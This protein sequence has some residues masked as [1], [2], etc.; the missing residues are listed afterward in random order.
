MNGLALL[1]TSVTAIAQDYQDYATE[2]R[3][4]LHQIPEL[5]WEEEQTIAYLLNEIAQFNI[6]SSIQLSIH[7][8]V[9]GFFVDVDIA[10]HFPRLLFRAD[11]DALPIEEALDIPYRSQF[12]NRMHACGH[13]CHA[14][15]LLAALKALCERD[16][17][18]TSNLRLVFQRAEE[19][20]P[21]KSGG[22]TLVH[23]GVCADIF[24]V[25]GLHIGTTLESGVFFSRPNEL[26][27]NTALIQFEIS[28][29]GGHV[30]RPHLGTNAIDV[31]AEIC[32]ALRGFERKVLD[33]SD[34][35]LF[36]PSMSEAAIANNIRPNFLKMTYAFRSFLRNDKKKQF[37]QAV[38][39][40]IE[41]IIAGFATTRLESFFVSDGYP[42]LANDPQ[43]VAMVKTML[44]SH[45]MQTE[46][47]LPLFAG[48]DFAY[49]L[50]H[51]P[52]SYW[53][54]G[55]KTGNGQDHHTPDF[56]PD[57]SILHKGIAFWL[58]LATQPNAQAL[59]S[60]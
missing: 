1:T 3:R 14:A 19:I 2:V 20:G 35:A 4:K 41:N 42:I 36:I 13:D 26:L 51:S 46:L 52:G 32:L 23:E 21:E 11:L 30:M 5:A 24:E 25:Y 9:G 47:S 18:L 44:E 22:K 49:Y 37:I 28:C 34:V 60:S 48:D 50:L 58:L 39:N 17:P 6:L 29:S 38:R 10:P 56:N 43:N 27:A 54:L 55:A 16:L 12:K 33:P 8:R 59:K 15:M 57:E 45:Q 31:Q 7:H 40:K 53:M